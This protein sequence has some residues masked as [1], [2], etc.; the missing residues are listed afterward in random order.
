[1][2]AEAFEKCDDISIDFAIL[3]YAKN[4]AVVLADFDW[5]DLGT[6]GSLTDHLAKDDN[7]NAVVGQKVFLYNSSNCL[8]H[9]PN[10]KLVLIDGLDDMIVVESNEML[11]VLK[12]ENEQDLKKYLKNIEDHSPHLFK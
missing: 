5:S 12:K 7:D 11:L 8:I 3:E 9:V 4:I 1:M 10:D 6:W 2:I